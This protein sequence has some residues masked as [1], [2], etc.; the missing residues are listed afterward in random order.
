MDEIVINWIKKVDQSIYNLYEMYSTNKGNILTEGD[1]ECHMFNNLITDSSLGQIQ[2]TKSEGYNSCSV[3]SQVT[4]FNQI[5]Q[6][7]YEVDLT[8]IDPAFLYPREIEMQEAF[9]SKNYYYDGP[10]LAIELKFVRHKSDSKAMIIEDY[11]KIMDLIRKD[12]HRNIEKGRYKRSTKDNIAFVS[13]IGFKE[14]EYLNH[15]IESL[16]EIIHSRDRSIPRDLVLYIMSPIIIK[17][18]NHD[19]GTFETLLNPAFSD[20][21]RLDLQ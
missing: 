6:S 15:S 10:C 1:L 11:K 3:H 21:T 2:K 14:H 19:S 8:I 12:K 5:R 7:G 16:L 13:I 4:W 18:Y 9:P 20:Q 17:K